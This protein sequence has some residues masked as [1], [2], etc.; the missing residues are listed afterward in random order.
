[1]QVLL[2]KGAVTLIMI[3]SKILVVMVLFI[4]FVVGLALVVVLSIH[5]CLLHKINAARNLNF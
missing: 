3:L 2:K 1:M 4:F 5:T